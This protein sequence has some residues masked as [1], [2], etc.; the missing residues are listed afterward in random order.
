MTIEAQK[1]ARI[2]ATY[3][4]VS[5]EDQ[6]E[7]DTIR[8]Q[9]DEL[10]RRLE[11]DPSAVLFKRYADNGV[12]GTRPLADRPSG[13]QLLRDA[14]SHLFNELWIYN[15]KRLGRKKIDLL[16]LQQRF[17]SL[18]IKV[19]SL[20]EGELTGIGFDIHAILADYDR[21]YFLNLSADGMNRAAREG[22]YTGGI[23]PL[24]YKVVGQKQTAHLE[25]STE[26]MWADLSEADVVRRLYNHL[27]LDGWSCVRIAKEFNGLGLPTDYIHDN[28]EVEIKGQRKK[29][30]QGVWRSG[31]IRNL[32]VNPIYKGVLQY[33]RRSD[34]PDREVI[35]KTIPSLALVSEEVWNAAQETLKRNRTI[36]PSA[37]RVYLLKSVIKCGNCGLTYVASWNENRNQVW[38]RCNGHLTGRGPTEGR[39]TAKDVKGD[40]LEPVVWTDIDTFLRDP[41]SDLIKE[42][43][44]EQEDNTSALVQEAERITLEKAMEQLAARRKNAIN[45]GTRGRITDAELDELL[46]EI[47]RKKAVVQEKLQALQPEVEE[48]PI[49]Q[50]DEDLVTELRKRLDAGLTPLQKQEIVRLLVKKIT[51]YT[52]GAERKRRA[53][54]EYRFTKPASVAVPTSTGRDSWRPPA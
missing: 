10:A 35:S 18:G 32:V 33:G 48:E 24:G 41:G 36:G 54:I 5:S 8:T 9:Q 49:K 52:E 46:D 21:E 7:R 19:I 42:L 37:G 4:R 39:C 14:E 28:R 26:T 20:Q 43:A 34:K 45:L 13:K 30:T 53:L 40:Y 16:V 51:I 15:L 17:K 47:T 1:A 12:T 3:E 11:S 2:V 23:V 31:H 27:T 6:R 25:P 29:H 50:L 44:G 38:Y 22:R